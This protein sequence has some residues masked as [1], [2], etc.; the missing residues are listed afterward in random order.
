M[1]MTDWLNTN[2]SDYIDKKEKILVDTRKNNGM[3]AIAAFG[4]SLI[5]SAICGFW[6]AFVGGGFAIFVFVCSL[7]LFLCII[8]NSQR[9]TRYV[10]T[11]F[12]IYKIT[13]LI[14]KRLKFVAYNQITD[15]S[16]YRGPVQR[17]VG[18]GSVGVGTASGNVTGSVVDG[19]G[20]VYSI[21][22][23]DIESVDDYKKIREV[24]IKN[25]KKK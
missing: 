10:L 8:Y 7:F 3:C 15:I 21:N 17:I 22:E 2:L 11:N 1:Q 13:G 14:F 24:I 5:L 25:T 20:T 18:A 23:L 16:M 12:G 9:S 19:N 4:I 6:G